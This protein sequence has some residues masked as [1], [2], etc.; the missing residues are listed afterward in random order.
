MQNDKIFS[1][2]YQPQ[3]ATQAEDLVQKEEL[4]EYELQEQIKQEVK[5]YGT[6]KP[7]WVFIRAN[8]IHD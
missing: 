6:G 1:P 4:I 8:I 7:R 3:I 2:E 5:Q